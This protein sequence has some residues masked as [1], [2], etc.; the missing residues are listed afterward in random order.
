MET[1]VISKLLKE[2]KTIA[3][4]GLSPK[5][6]RPSHDVARYLIA[7]GYTIIPV[8]PGQTEI[9]GL[10]CYPNLH[11]IPIRIDVVDIFRRSELVPPIV[12]EAIAI[13]AK[14]IWMQQGIINEASARKA[15]QAGLKVFMDRCLKIDHMNLG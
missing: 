13:K 6:D 11:A 14:A 10:P 2:I 15:R 3:I 7:A 8:N 1:L 12:D 5:P 4:V 9:L